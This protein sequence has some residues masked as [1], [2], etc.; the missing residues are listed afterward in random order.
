MTWG[1]PADPNGDIL[2]YHLYVMLDPRDAAYLGSMSLDEN[3]SNTSTSYV[4]AGLH[5]FAVYFL[6]LAASTS[7]GIGNRT[8]PIEMRTGTAGK[9]YNPILELRMF[10]IKF[11]LLSGVN[12]K[13]L[14]TDQNG[15]KISAVRFLF[16]STVEV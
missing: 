7:A 9:L 4:V 8:E 15:N 3:V 14:I 13:L 16:Y 2:S 5:E 1:P 10:G 12:S 11:F 6:S